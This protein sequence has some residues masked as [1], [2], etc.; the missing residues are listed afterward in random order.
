M[1]KEQEEQLRDIRVADD[2]NIQLQKWMDEED[3]NKI[4]DFIDKNYISKQELKEKIEKWQN[5]W[6]RPEFEY[7]Y[8]VIE[9]LLKELGLNNKLSNKKYGRRNN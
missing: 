8:Q 3:L 2:Y 9:D 6:L 5:C 7:E 1:N 4:I